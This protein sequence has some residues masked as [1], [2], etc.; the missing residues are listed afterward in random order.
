MH[1]A[2]DEGLSGAVKDNDSK[3]PPEW[4]LSKSGRK[5]A[6]PIPKPKAK[7]KAKKK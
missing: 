1:E 6:K 2:L 7:A 3:F 4:R 5:D